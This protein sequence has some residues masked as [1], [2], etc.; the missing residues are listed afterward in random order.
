MM[1]LHF[2]GRWTGVLFICAFALFASGCESR[3]AITGKVLNDGQPLAKAELRW[4]SETNSS[5]FVGGVTDASGNIIVDAGGKQDIPVGKYKV[6]VVWWRLANGQPLPE[7]EQG[8]A[9]KSTPGAAKQYSATLDVEIT[10]ATTKVE[11]DVTGKGSVVDDS[12][13]ASP[14]P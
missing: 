9:A 8:T 4:V 1:P 12:K 13:P 10:K 6:T 5:V 3:V 14:A 7:G 2:P 11:F